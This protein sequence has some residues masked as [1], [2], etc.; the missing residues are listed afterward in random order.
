[1]TTTAAPASRSG[2]TSTGLL[3]GRLDREWQRLRYDARALRT[4]RSWVRPAPEAPIPD[5]PI[6]EAPDPETRPTGSTADATTTE[7]AA[8]GRVRPDGPLGTLLG[9]LTDLQDVITATHRDAEHRGDEILL[10]LVALAETEELA[11]RIVLQRILPALLARSS[12]YG[13][14]RSG[15]TTADTVVATAWVTL[16]TYD[17]RRRR[18]QVAAS[19]VSDAVYAAFRQPYRRRAATEQLRPAESWARRPADDHP[20]ALE[21]LAA[22][23]AEARRHGVGCHDLDVLRSLAR[24][25]S[26]TV[27]AAELGVTAR[28]VRNRRDRA[29]ARVRAAVLTD[30]A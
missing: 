29:I 1:M 6:R 24:T 27:V 22:I 2:P 23:V 28:T 30:A 25:G 5:V 11:G 8:A 20:T 4:A 16:R 26:S 9:G 12:P 3:T 10:E 14:H 7:R 17:H 13:D 18:R 21:E 15:H 19:I